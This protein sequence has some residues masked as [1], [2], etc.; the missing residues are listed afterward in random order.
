MKKIHINNIQESLLKSKILSEAM[1]DS[2]SFDEL[3]VL[4]SF[5]QRKKYCDK[6]LGFNVGKG[7]S[8]IV[9]QIDDN[10]VLKLAWNEKGVAQNEQE[11]SFSQENFVDVTPEVFDDMSDTENYLFITS[12][13]VLPAKKQDFK[14]VFGISFEKFVDVLYTVASWYDAKTYRFYS[15]LSDAEMEMLQDNNENIKEYVDYVSN[16]QPPIGDMVRVANYGLINRNGEDYIV[17]LDSGLSEDIYNT[18]YKRNV[19][20]NI[21]VHKGEVGKH[22]TTQ[23]T[24]EDSID[25]PHC[26]SK[27]FFSM[28]ISD[29]N[30]GRGRIKVTDE[31]GKETDSEVQTIALYYCPKCYRFTALNN[32][33]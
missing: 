28:S 31:N 4:K 10:K 32:M 5:A 3:K 14:H 23:A 25:C 9:Y 18:Y 1:M 16:Y 13:Y 11:Y 21:K 24:W 15:K 20:E 17:L 12:E 8:R 33:A 2:F 19:Y 27:A 22:K 7:S 6:Y 30:K 26:N 29:G